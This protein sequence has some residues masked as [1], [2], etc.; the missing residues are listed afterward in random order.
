[1]ALVA[2]SAATTAAASANQ[3]QAL[4]MP[5]GL[6]RAVEIELAAP[7]ER[8]FVHIGTIVPAALALAVRARSDLHAQLARALQPRC[9]RQHHELEIVAQARKH[10]VVRAVGVE[11]H[12]RL[13]R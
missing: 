7:A 4:S 2:W 3:R 1:M 13:Q 9:G 5:P 10:L 6:A 12:L 11:V 8:F